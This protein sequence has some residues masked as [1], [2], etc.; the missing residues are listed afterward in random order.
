MKRAFAMG[1]FLSLL[2][3]PAVVYAL[4]RA[5][6]WAP[7]AERAAG[8]EVQRIFYFHVPFAM[9]AFLGF[10]IVFL[11]GVSYL[12]RGGR[13]WDLTAHAAAEIGLLCCTIVLLTGP[14]WAR[15]AWG[16]WW[17]WDA[18]LTSTLV[19]WLIYAGY[20]VLRGAMAGDPRMPRYAAV[21]GIVGACDVPIVYFSVQ[22]FRGQ[23]PTT[24]V[25]KQ[26]GLAPEMHTALRFG[27]LAVFII[28]AALLFQRL[29]VGRMEAEI[30]DLRA[31]AE[32]GE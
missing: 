3:I 5:L 9:T 23:H 12:L 13:T 19:L 24:A 20:L 32:E 11:A 28:F 4:D 30:E 22:W 16:V 29:Q 26:G 8:G 6:L 1:H 31:A 14:V 15:Y 10:G 18:R 17:T 25:L 7:T 2:S 21:L 27:M